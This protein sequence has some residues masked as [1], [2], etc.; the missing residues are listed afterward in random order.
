MKNLKKVG[1]TALAGSLVAF[2]AN[3]VEMSVSGTAEVSYT[4]VGGTTANT[5]NA[6]GSN[7]SLSFS[8]EGD[9]GGGTAK[10]VRTFDDNL[11]AA[12]S[13][14]QT[15]DMGDMG[16]LSFDGNGGGLEGTTAY[17]DVLPTAYEEVWTGVSGDGVI[18]AAS[19]DTIGYRNTLMGLTVSLAR[20][21]GGTAGTGDGAGDGEGVTATQSDW[22]LSYA[23]PY[24]DGLTVSYGE[25]TK[26]FAIASENDDTSTVGHI[27]YSTGPVSLGYRWAEFHDGTGGANGTNVD[28]YAVAFNVSD[29][30]KVSFA[31]QDR[32]FDVPSGTNVTETTD[33][34]NAAYTVGAATVRATFSEAT[35]L[36]GTTGENDEHMEIS[37]VLAF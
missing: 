24:L 20:T 4:T 1:L 36:S 14:W 26:D 10:I 29:E 3:A 30:M 32:E 16:K 15:L 37:L 33:A 22:H 11:G 35:N 9:V 23:V 5:G 2:S 28:A 19:N 17:D 27:L 21:A 18:G 8:G 34:V 13:T 12:L 7:T 31:T 25:S 6:W